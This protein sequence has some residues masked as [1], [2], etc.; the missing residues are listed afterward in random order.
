[1]I[2]VNTKIHDKFSIEFKTSFVTR[3]K[4][5]KNDFSAYMWFFVPMSLDINKETYPKSQF[6]QDIKSN[7][8]LIT[9]KFLLRD[10]VSGSALPL[11]RLRE[12]FSNLASSPTR[13]AKRE[14]EYQIK[15]FAAITHSSGRDACNYIV[16]G[17]H[18]IDE[19]TAMC[20][21]YID[22]YKAVLAHYRELKSIIS[23]PTITDD[24]MSCYRYGDEYLSN[25]MLYYST[26]L[27]DHMLKEQQSSLMQRAINAIQQ[28]IKDEIAYRD[29]REYA[30]LKADDPNGNRDAMFRHR[31]LKKYVDSDLFLDVPKKKDGNLAE[32]LY[33]S[34]AAGLAMMFATV[35]SFHFQQ[36]FGNFTLPFFIVLVLSYMIKDRIKELS[37]YYFAHR[38]G[39]KFFDNKAEILIKDEKIGTIKEGMDFIS[40]KKLPADVK[41]VRYS[42]R[43]ME[44]E[45]RV[46]DE[47]IL[48][49]RMGVHI[50][51]EK[52]NGMTPYETTGIND[53]IR[54]NVDTFLRKMDNPQVMRQ[55]MNDD[56]TISHVLCDK[57]YYI[58]IV[59]QFSFEDTTTLRRF[60][61]AVNR[62]GIDS[63][64]E[65]I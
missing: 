1:M 47:K 56:G 64:N 33:L 3:R 36:K 39:S 16:E 28:C 19:K 40:H 57:L 60:R 50:N 2:E 13:T 9:P 20:L 15:M 44:A 37:R 6:Y 41:R 61:V 31:V 24:M 65:V 59:L 26:N 30:N 7:V 42:H 29:D 51:R 27:L 32:Q 55:V 63:I 52:L 54:F 21:T 25:M 46:S 58:N 12:S 14:Y 18:R 35:V 34:I 4:L 17:E 11:N 49:Y 23:Q 48:L 38:I 43:L 45:N 22:D 53:I 8:R 10:I 5:K 62:N